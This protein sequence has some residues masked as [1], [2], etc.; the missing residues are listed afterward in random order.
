MS[1]PCV[2]WEGVKEPGTISC[3]KSET[4]KRMGRGEG[5]GVD[6]RVGEECTD[7]D[8]F[9]LVWRAD[10]VEVAEGRER[11][12]EGKNV[13]DGRVEPGTAATESERERRVGRLD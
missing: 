7:L 11:A 9:P 5:K 3:R 13:D 8:G 1:D 12:A 6:L 2:F 4:D 10:W